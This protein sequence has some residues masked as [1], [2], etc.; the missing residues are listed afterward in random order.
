VRWH[1]VD[2]INERESR[3]SKLQKARDEGLTYD[4]IS[5]RFGISKQRVHQII[6]K[7]NTSLFR[8]ITPK[9]CVYDGIRLWMNKN[10][11]STAELVRRIYGRTGG[12]AYEM[13]RRRLTGI[14]ELTKTYIDKILSITNLTYE[15]AF[16]RSD[17]DVLS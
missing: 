9:M 12:E 6:G 14:N 10:K 2:E 17:T 8:P 5:R 3:K 4:E 7:S 11:I 15:E 13:T 1:T 16:K